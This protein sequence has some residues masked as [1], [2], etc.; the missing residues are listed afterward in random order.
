MLVTLAAL[1]LAS[2][3]L[4]EAKGHLK[5]GKVD[6]VFFA[7]DG[8]TLPDGEKPEAS[9]VLADAGKK[10]LSAKDGVMALSLGKMAIKLDKT[11]VL[12]LEVSSRASRELEQFTDAENFADAWLKAEP[13]STEAAVWRAEL[14][15]DAGDWS[16]ALALLDTVKTKSTATAKAKQLRDRAEKELAS[17]QSGLSG[18]RQLERDLAKAQTEYQASG[19][20][21]TASATPSRSGG[22]VLYGTT[23]CGYCK[24][25]RDYFKKKG[26]QFVDKDVEKDEGAAKELAD[27]AART[28]ARVSGVPV[29]DVR[30][31][32]VM[33]F[34][35]QRIE[36]LL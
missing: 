11:N 20:T 36:K 24:K 22:I 17:R 12:A 35:V 28:G 2:A 31:T 29:I 32:L 4:D 18:L 15:I 9:R 1:L 21:V 26:V 34:D 16:G 30:G 8:K 3:P 14:S 27:K 6:E 23:W 19:R 25:A 33:G 10:A 5:A 13:A 7:L